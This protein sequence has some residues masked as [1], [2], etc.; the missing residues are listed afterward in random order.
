MKDEGSG[1]GGYGK[2]FIESS[3]GY[4]VVV[5][6]LGSDGS[7]KEERELGWNGMELVLG[8]N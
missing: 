1:D 3:N 2:Q 5:V 6:G 8:L 7:R 4:L